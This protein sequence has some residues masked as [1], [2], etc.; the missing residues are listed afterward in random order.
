MLQFGPA[1]GMN[2]HAQIT[3]AI[4]ERSKPYKAVMPRKII[5][6]ISLALL[7]GALV[8]GSAIYA[9]RKASLYKIIL[10]ALL[11]I[12]GLTFFNIACELN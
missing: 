6:Y 10:T 5:L 3:N 11:T 7:F 8:N 1:K 9:T 2:A 12:F 4:F